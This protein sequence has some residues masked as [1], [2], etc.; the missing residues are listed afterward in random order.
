[1]EHSF[2]ALSWAKSAEA[3]ACLFQA[4]D[5][6]HGF[7]GPAHSLVS[8]LSR[9]MHVAAFQSPDN[10]SCSVALTKSVFIVLLCACP[11]RLVAVLPG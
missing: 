9:E 1:M 11:W 5:K 6:I 2:L 8:F 10:L 4:M 7:A 3:K